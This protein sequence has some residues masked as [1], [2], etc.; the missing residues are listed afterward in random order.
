MQ[1]KLKRLLISLVA[2]VGLVGDALANGSANGWQFFQPSRTGYS[3]RTSI[4]YHYGYPAYGPSE[5]NVSAQFLFNVASGNLTDLVG[6]SEVLVVNTTPTFNQTI[7]GLHA[8]ISPGILYDA[9]TE[10]HRKGSASTVMSAGTS[11]F[12]LEIWFS[13]T[14]AGDAMLVTTR[15]WVSGD[16][17]EVE[18]LP[19]ST[20]IN[21]YWQATDN[22]NVTSTKSYGAAT[23]L[24]GNPHKIRITGD[25]NGNLTTYLDE[26]SLGTT[27]FAAL[28]GKDLAADDVTMAVAI[29][30]GA[31]TLTGKLYEVRL[32]LNLTNNSTPTWLQ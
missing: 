26:T 24:D 17:Y 16:G 1:A 22:T 13:S 14:A 9:N 8:G 31:K 23:P 11:D 2:V 28:D 7:G 15:G 20:S 4:G 19:G 6:G 10:Y 3:A 32:S 18:I 5:S 25:R 30:A 12:T 27:A 29:G 21:S